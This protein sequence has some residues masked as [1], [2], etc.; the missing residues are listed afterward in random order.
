MEELRNF[1]S[2]TIQDHEDTLDPDNPRDFI[3]KSQFYFMQLGNQTF[4]IKVN[5]LNLEIFNRAKNIPVGLQ[6]STIKI[7][8]KSVKGST[9]YD[10]TYTHF[11]RTQ[12]IFTGKLTFR[13]KVDPLNL[14][15]QNQAKDIPVAL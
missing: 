6:S 5:Q 8:G 9:S 15:C 13:F 1:I 7:L 10:R 11:T 4:S 3:G 2:E 12:T 14:E